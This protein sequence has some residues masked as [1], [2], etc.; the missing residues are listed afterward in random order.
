M[1]LFSALGI[2][3]TADGIY[4]VFYAVGNGFFYFPPIML[5][6]TAAKRFH[7]NES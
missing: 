7:C 2:L 4:M 3:S 6:Y 1:A 5:D